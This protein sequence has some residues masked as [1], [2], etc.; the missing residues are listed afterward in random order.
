MYSELLS[1][2]YKLPHLIRQ[3]VYLKKIMCCIYRHL[4]FCR[5]DDF[6]DMYQALVKQIETEGFP[7]FKINSHIL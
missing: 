7:G 1:M 4:S 5:K 6:L 2:P 3:G